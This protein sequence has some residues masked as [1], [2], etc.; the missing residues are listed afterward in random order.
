MPHGQRL[1]ATAIETFLRELLVE[2][3]ETTSAHPDPRPTTRSE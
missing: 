1:A 2:G 3:Q